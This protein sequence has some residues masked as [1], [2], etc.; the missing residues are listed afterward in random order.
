MESQ[1]NW[2]WKVLWFDVIW[3]W[4]Y[5]ANATRTPTLPLFRSPSFTTCHWR[6]LF[7]PV[8]KHDNRKSPSW[9]DD[10]R[11]TSL[12]MFP[13][14]ADFPIQ[15]PPKNRWFPTAFF[16]GGARLAVAGAAAPADPRT[17]SSLT[18]SL[19][20][21]HSNRCKRKGSRIWPRW[22]SQGMCLLPWFWR[23]EELGDR[24]LYIYIIYKG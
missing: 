24:Y 17:A 10:F 12:W 18:T 13:F 6:P 14:L 20:W 19:W 7:H 9:F 5:V 4:P 11:T 16:L 1:K 2:I 3:M 22:G 15:S 21:I 23:A 8:I